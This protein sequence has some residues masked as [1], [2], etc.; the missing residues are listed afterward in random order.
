MAPELIG[1]DRANAERGKVR[2]EVF[3]N[4]GWGSSRACVALV[5]VFFH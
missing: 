2:G 3:V 4:C 5:M 1:R